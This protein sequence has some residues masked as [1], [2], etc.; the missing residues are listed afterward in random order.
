MYMTNERCVLVKHS[1]HSLTFFDEYSLSLASWDLGVLGDQGD[2]GEMGD[3]IRFFETPPRSPGV[4]DLLIQ[5][6]NP[7][8]P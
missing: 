1:V 4:R 3:S 5:P 8:T 6:P 2:Q 7:R